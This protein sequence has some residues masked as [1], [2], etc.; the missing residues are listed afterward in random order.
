MFESW[1]RASTEE[2]ADE[3]MDS[4]HYEWSVA[5]KT[6]HMGMAAGLALGF[7]LYYGRR[8]RAAAQRLVIR[9]MRLVVSERPT[10][11]DYYGALWL[12][13]GSRCWVREIHNRAWH[14]PRLPSA[15]QSSARAM[16]ASLAVQY[17]NFQR[18]LEVVRLVCTCPAPLQHDL[19]GRG[20]ATGATEF[21]CRRCGGVWQGQPPT[22]PCYTP[23]WD[24]NPLL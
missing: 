6:T 17:S 4:I 1:L 14:Q 12:T 18:Q 15:V 11:N 9:V 7:H 21:H 19:A 10:W 3:V 13:T 22:S 23:P 20:P 2:L 8:W 24:D 16:E 5:E